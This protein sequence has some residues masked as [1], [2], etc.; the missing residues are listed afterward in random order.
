MPLSAWATPAAKARKARAGL[1]D[2]LST[3]SAKT[4]A[5]SRSPPRAR[6]PIRL[7][8]HPV[9]AADSPREV[10]A[11]RSGR[12][13][14]EASTTCKAAEFTR[15]LSLLLQPQTPVQLRPL[16]APAWVAGGAAFVPLALH[17]QAQAVRRPHPLRVEFPSPFAS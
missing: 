1:A 12:K 14:G 9:A 3:R 7:K 11:S 8:T 6:R 4:A 13:M 16:P 10:L 2:P 5:G 17:Q 15:S